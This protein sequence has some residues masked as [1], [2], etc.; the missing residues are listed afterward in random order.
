M[1]VGE[2]FSFAVTPEMIK[3]CDLDFS[4]LC[5][6]MKDGRAS[7][8]FLERQIPHWFPQLVW[9]S[10]NKPYDF[11]H[12]ETGERFELKNFTSYGCNFC[13]SSHIGAGRKL[14]KEVAA[15]TVSQTTYIICDIR[16]VPTFTLKCE[17]GPKLLEQYP[18]FRIDKA[19]FD[20]GP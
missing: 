18:N 6:L 8:H 9:E 12:S 1:K 15:I 2:T 11:T 14:N 4:S 10:K 16:K 20:E 7:S 5:N 19:F 13:P 17:R 3:F